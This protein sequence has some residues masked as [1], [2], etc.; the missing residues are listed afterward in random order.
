MTRPIDIAPPNPK[1][2]GQRWIVCA[3]LFGATAVNYVDRQMIG[4]LKPTLTAQFGWNESDFATIIFWFQMAY[5]TGYIGF[6]RLVDLIG[7]RLGYIFAILVW[8]V[9]HMAHGFAVGAASFAGARFVLGLGESGNYPA[10]IRAVADWFPQ[11]ERALAI[12]LFNAGANV[13]AI[14]TPL[15]VPLLVLWFGWRAA[16]FITGLFGVV[17]LVAWSK[18]YRHP[19]Q[20]P[21]V[22]AGELAWIRQDPADTPVTIGWGQLLLLR[23]TWCYALGRFLIDPVWWFYLFWLP[24]Y[25]FE[26][27]HL[28][29]KSFGVPL[30]AIYILSDCG[31]VAGGWLSSALIRRGHSVNAARKTAMAVCAVAVA[32]I[33]F[34][35]SIDSVWGA[36]LVIGLASAA[37]QAFSANLYTL[38]SDM[39]PRAAVGSVVGIGGTVG[40]LGGMGMALLTGYI[41]DATHSYAVLFAGCALAYLAALAAIHLLSP[42]LA[43]VQPG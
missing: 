30:A 4:V 11:R 1:S 42:R 2:G 13:G 33:W 24:G 15:L 41:L 12:G 31:S 23:E 26:R 27:Y 19:E 17:W 40:A 5:A 28:D 14:I 29:L 3:L 20:N 18:F 22:T 32:P 21:K 39:F 25:L 7:A 16:F 8:T 36:V 35:Q 37:H 43:P 9:G 6:G 10:G 38:P 34:A